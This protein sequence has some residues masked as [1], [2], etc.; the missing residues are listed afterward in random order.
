VIELPAGVVGDLDGEETESM[1][2]AARRELLEETGYAAGRLE[3][4]FHGAP[5]AGITD[6]EQ[7]FFLAKEL[8]KVTA[9]GGDASEDIIV[10][11][12]PVRAVEGWLAEQMTR[13]ATVDPRVYAGI[14]FASSR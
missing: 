3:H 5:S 10:H 13:G 7:D 9:G 8:R 1:E 11:A 12:V 2:A 6:E 14:Y 4:L